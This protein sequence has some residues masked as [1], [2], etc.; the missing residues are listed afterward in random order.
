VNVSFPVSDILLASMDRCRDWVLHHSIVFY[1][2]AA[3]SAEAFSV[4]LQDA[5]RA[6]PA[7]LE[8]VVRAIADSGAYR[9]RVSVRSAF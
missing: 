6:D 8:Q 5:G 3:Q 7:F 1:R 9:V 4:G 2:S